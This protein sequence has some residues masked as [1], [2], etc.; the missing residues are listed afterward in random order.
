VSIGVAQPAGVRFLSTSLYRWV[1]ERNLCHLTEVGERRAESRAKPGAGM[2]TAFPPQ[3]CIS[4][5]RWQ[6]HEV[7]EAITDC[8][9]LCTCRGGPAALSRKDSLLARPLPKRPHCFATAAPLPHHPLRMAASDHRFSQPLL[10]H[11]GAS[12]SQASRVIPYRTTPSSEPSPIKRM[13]HRIITAMD[14]LRWGNVSAATLLTSG[15][16]NAR[17]IS[18]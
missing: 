9:L 7:R 15:W 8:Y 6:A 10:S 12:C 2:S 5:L 17:S 3:Y 16:P 13:P 11:L 18:A 1:N 4:S 14:A